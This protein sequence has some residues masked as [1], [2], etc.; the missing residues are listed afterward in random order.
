MSNTRKTYPLLSHYLLCPVG[1]YP[2][3]PI[4][5]IGDIFVL[6]P[7]VSRLLPVG[8][9]NEA[10]EVVLAQK[11]QDVIDMAFVNDPTPAQ[12]MKINY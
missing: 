5:K 11:T 6:L 3:V 12:V 7:H 2:A 4:C 8:Q 1:E 9:H 10:R